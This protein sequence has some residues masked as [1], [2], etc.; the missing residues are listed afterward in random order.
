MDQTMAHFM[1]F[2]AQGDG[3]ILAV[4]WH[5]GA[6]VPGMGRRWVNTQHETGEILDCHGSL[7][8]RDGEWLVKLPGCPDRL[9]VFTD[10][11]FRKVFQPANEPAR[12]LALWDCDEGRFVPC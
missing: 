5:Q 1:P 11:E 12:Q 9:F 2:K 8:V 4:R 6:V 7:H 10:D 3:R